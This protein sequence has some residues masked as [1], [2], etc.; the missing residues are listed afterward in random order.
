[1]VLGLCSTSVP[2]FF[3]FFTDSLLIV[4]S[5]TGIPHFRIPVFLTFAV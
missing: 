1:M 5:H 3:S 4:A 2:R